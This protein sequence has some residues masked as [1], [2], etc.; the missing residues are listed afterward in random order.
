[1]GLTRGPNYGMLTG[2]AE[3]N[4]GRSERDWALTLLL[5]APLPVFTLVQVFP[6]YLRVSLAM[7]A[8]VLWAATEPGIT[9]RIR[10]Q[11]AAALFPMVFVACG[12]VLPAYAYVLVLTFY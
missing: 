10:L 7:I 11:I 3:P 9:G 12:P 2:M 1:M 5:L 4:S 8:I 6:W